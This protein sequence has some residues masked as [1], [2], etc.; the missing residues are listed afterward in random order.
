MDK[1]KTV[2]IGITILILAFSG[3]Q[4]VAAQ[5]KVAVTY[6]YIRDLVRQVGGDRVEVN[7]LS[8]GQWDPHTVVPRPSLIALVRKADLLIMNGAQLEIGW[9]PPLL[10]QANNPKV[11]PSKKG[12]LDLSEHFEMIQKPE[13]ISRAE[14]DIHPAGNP[15]FYLDPHLYGKMARLIGDKLIEL[16]PAGKE[17][18]VNRVAEF[19]GRWQ[20]NLARWDQAMAP[21]KGIKVIEYHRN[22]DYFLL[23]YGIEIPATVELLPGIPPTTKHVMDLIEMAGREKI[24]FV[25]HDVYHNKKSSKYLA[26]E[27]QV[28]MIVLPH[29]VEAVQEAGSLE[30]LF[31]SI[32]ERMVRK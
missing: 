14:G 7:S 11:L 25:V 10:Q 31:D 17:G 32:V 5:L 30:G 13:S 16:D 18:Y 3:L 1:K 21:L 22:L 9:L 23:A 15:H 28:P 19:Q 24:S 8:N 29:D 12:F 27:I 6:T 26:D 4:A 20:E 2:F